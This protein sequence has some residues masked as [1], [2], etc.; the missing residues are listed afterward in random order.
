MYIEDEKFVNRCWLLNLKLA[1]T[2]VVCICLHACM[3][4]HLHLYSNN[5]PR[6]IFFDFSFLDPVLFFLM[7][8]SDMKYCHFLNGVLN[9]L[10]I[11]QTQWIHSKVQRTQMQVHC[12]ISFQEKKHFLHPV[13]VYMNNNDP[14][15][16]PIHVMSMLSH[17]S[18]YM[19]GRKWDPLARTCILLMN[20]FRAGMLHLTTWNVNMWFTY[21]S[22]LQTGVQCCQYLDYEVNWQ[23]DKWTRKDLEGSSYSI[24]EGIVRKT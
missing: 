24:I 3:H 9:V 17:T 23:I 8:W 13:F 16:S 4:L 2:V 18:V 1:L 12:H 11:H 10:F 20:A 15:H 6:S 5:A 7:L 22:S 21:H 19:R 14:L